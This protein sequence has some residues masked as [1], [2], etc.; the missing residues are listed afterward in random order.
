MNKEEILAK[1]QQE[2][3]KKNKQDERELAETARAGQISA[4]FGLIVAMIIVLLNTCVGFFFRERY[5]IRIS[6]AA[7]AVCAAIYAAQ[8]FYSYKKLHKKGYLVLAIIGVVLFTVTFIPLV[9][10]MYGVM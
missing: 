4:G 2:F 5:D 10:M 3:N 7:W 6:F 9:L 8:G 1:S